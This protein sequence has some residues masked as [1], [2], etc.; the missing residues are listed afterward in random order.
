MLSFEACM[1]GHSTRNTA[2]IAAG[3]TQ[4]VVFTATPM[5][6]ATLRTVLVIFATMAS[7]MGT[8]IGVLAA[9]RCFERTDDAVWTISVWADQALV[10]LTIETS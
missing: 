6:R 9:R 8:P 3:A 2:R 10:V 7:N 1:T 5:A 4:G